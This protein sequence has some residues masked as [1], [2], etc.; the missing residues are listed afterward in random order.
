MFDIPPVTL[1]ELRYVDEHSEQLKECALAFEKVVDHD[2]IIHTRL[3]GH[4]NQWGYV[5]IVNFSNKDDQGEPLDQTQFMCWTSDG[6]D[7]TLA[8]RPVGERRA[9]R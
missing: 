2:V 3:S 5:L 4:S 1:S 8:V 6:D 7:I 9:S